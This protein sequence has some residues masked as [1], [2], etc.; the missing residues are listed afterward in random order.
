MS[1]IRETVD[2]LLSFME[3]DPQAVSDAWAHSAR[4]PFD[5]PFG[6]WDMCYTPDGFPVLNT[7]FLDS[8]LVSGQTELLFGSVSYFHEMVYDHGPTPFPG[9]A[10]PIANVAEETPPHSFYDY[11]HGRT[12][13]AC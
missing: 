6:G 1:K 11:V 9:F 7:T 3:E 10:D 12:L 4:F 13:I 2:R 8:I 5:E